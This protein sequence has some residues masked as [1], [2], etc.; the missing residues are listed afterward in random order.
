MAQ[1]KLKPH[2]SESGKLPLTRWRD[3][4]AAL[5]QEY[6]TGQAELSPLYADVKKLWNIKFAVEKVLREQN[7]P[8]HDREHK[9]DQER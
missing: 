9:H 7:R 6:K 1:R 4:L 3:E 2:F 5:Q 8:Q